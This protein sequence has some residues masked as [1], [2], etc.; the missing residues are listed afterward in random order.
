MADMGAP[1]SVVSMQNEPTVSVNYYGMAWSAAHQEEFL[2][3]YGHYFTGTP[4]GVSAD[5][6]FVG[7]PGAGGIIGGGRRNNQRVLLQTGTPHNLVGGLAA[8]H[9]PTLNNATARANAEVTGFHTYG[10]WASRNDASINLAI[11]G[12]PRRESWMMEKNINSHAAGGLA[13][14]MTDQTWD[15]IWRKIDEIHHII[16]HNDANAYVWWYSKRWYSMI[17]EGAFGA[18]N[19]AILNRGYGMGHFSRFL[20]DTMRVTARLSG[21]SAGIGP[22]NQGFLNPGATQAYRQFSGI[23]VLA[24]VR[25]TEPSTAIGRGEGFNF[26]EGGYLSGIKNREDMVSVLLTDNRLG[27]AGQHHDINVELPEGFVATM[28]YAIVSEEHRQHAAHPVVLAADGRSGI[29]R[30]PSNAMVS[31]RFRGSWGN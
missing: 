30:L 29:V 27:I 1:I 17:G 8:F 22:N 3:L 10:G 23:R 5:D 6:G 24:G 25:E 11:T 26:Q 13:G 16:A 15:Y 20:T 18:P 9:T 31:V 14:A 7:V 12:T 4:A 19:H 28:A 21:I 2:R